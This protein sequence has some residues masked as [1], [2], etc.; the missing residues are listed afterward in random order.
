MAVSNTPGEPSDPTEGV[1]DQD[2]QAGDESSPWGGL[3]LSGL[4]GLGS[5]DDSGGMGDMSGMLAQVQQMQQQLMEAQEALAEAEFSGSAGGD[6]VQ[7]TVSGTGEL[8]SLE[9]KP[10]AC[11]PSDTDTLSDL[12]VAAVRSAMERQ[13]S[14]AAAKLGPMAGGLGI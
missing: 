1:G 4:G 14:E 13:R 3:D 10:E 7:A 5:Q 2:Q 11:D 8:S 9:I 12:V 6:L